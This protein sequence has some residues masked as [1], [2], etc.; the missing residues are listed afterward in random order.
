MTRHDGGWGVFSYCSITQ[1]PLG[2]HKSFFGG[3]L[4]WL[5]AC[6]YLEQVVEVKGL[7]VRGVKHYRLF[8]FCKWVFL[9]FCFY[10]IPVICALCVYKE[11]WKSLSLSDETTWVMQG[12]GPRCRLMFSSTGRFW[13]RGTCYRWRWQQSGSKIPSLQHQLITCKGAAA[14][15]AGHCSNEGQW[16][17]LS[18]SHK[19]ERRIQ[20]IMALAH[21]HT[22]F[23]DRK[24]KK[25]SIKLHQ[26]GPERWLSSCYYRLAFY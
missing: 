6:P 18:V 1:S 25:K 26:N 11:L 7:I 20:N 2:K 15:Q 8:L 23:G 3:P 22:T 21:I 14:Q 13:G 24:K 9:L 16:A 19:E 12:A 17:S 4:S 5:T 10:Y